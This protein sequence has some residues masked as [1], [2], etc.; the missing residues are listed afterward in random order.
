M[1]LDE[2]AETYKDKM[3]FFC[4]YIQEAHPDDGW[5]VEHNIEQDAVFNAPVN[6]EERAAMAEICVLRLD[7]KMPMLLDNMSNEVDGKYNAL[8]ER[9]Y[10][11]DAKGRVTFKTVAGSPG[12]DPEAWAEAIKAEVE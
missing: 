6:I 1:R 10:V 9:L 4:V 5:Q 8:P 7:M 11:L 3:D 2:I 12:F